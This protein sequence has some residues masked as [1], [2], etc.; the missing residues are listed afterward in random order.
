MPYYYFNDN[1]DDK[2]N[3]EVH[4]EDCSFIPSVSN[5]TLIGL[6]SNC[7]EAISRA[8]RENIYKS[9]DGCYYC[10]RPCHKG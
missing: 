9:F 5:R 4:T 6:E 2:G 8:K 10:C 1:T 7:S 3:H